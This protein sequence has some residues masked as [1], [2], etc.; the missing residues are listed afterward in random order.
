M[1]ERLCA[2]TMHHAAAHLR[3]LRV[4]RHLT[5]DELRLRAVVD[6]VTHV[7]RRDLA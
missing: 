4:A 7:G 5:T 6:V 2:C 1:T 3:M